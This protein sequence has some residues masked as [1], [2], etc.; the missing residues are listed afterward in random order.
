MKWIPCVWVSLCM[1]PLFAVESS[2]DLLKREREQTAQLAEKVSE[3][4]KKLLDGILKEVMRLEQSAKNDGDLPLFLWTH[5]VREDMRA[6]GNGLHWLQEPVE[7]P[8]KLER[9]RDQWRAQSQGLVENG[10]LAEERRLKSARENLDAH[11]RTLTRGGEIDEAVRARDLF[12]NH[13]RHK[14]FK[15]LQRALD[16]IQESTR[17]V[18]RIPNR[19]ESVRDLP[20]DAR[21]YFNADHPAFQIFLKRVT[22]VSSGHLGVKATGIRVRGHPDLTGRRGLNV[23][24]VY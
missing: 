19:P 3:N 17:P 23:M 16:L 13:E 22:A 18:A 24:A 4:F 20:P 14:A 8:P 15:A 6:H 10:L 21:V 1:I 12:Q 11:V 7:F 5:W 2:E 9:M